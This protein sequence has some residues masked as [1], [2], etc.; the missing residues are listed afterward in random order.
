MSE[1]ELKLELFER[2]GKY[3][4]FINDW[5][6][7]DLE[8]SEWTHNVQKAILSAYRIGCTQMR[9][10]VAE[11]NIPYCVGQLFPEHKPMRG[12]KLK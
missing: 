2:D 9:K 7:W 3:A 10:K 8:P 12:M 1:Q 6:V 4:A 5:S 11:T